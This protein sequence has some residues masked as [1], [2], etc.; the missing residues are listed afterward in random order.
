MGEDICKS[1]IRWGVN[2]QNIQW[3]HTTQQQ[4]KKQHD[5]KMGRGAE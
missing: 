3:T 5:L 2:I 4:Q 1:H